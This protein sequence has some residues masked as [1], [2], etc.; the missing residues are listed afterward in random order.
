[1]I[2]IIDYNGG[3]IGSL[4]N[5]IAQLGFAYEIIEHGRQISSDSHII[6]AGVGSAKSTLEALAKQ[7]FIEPLCSIDN[8]ILGICIG[9]HLFFNQLE[10]DQCN[11][12]GI[13]DASILQF[14]K[15]MQV[16]H[17]GWNRVFH[18]EH[19]LFADIASGSY[20]YFAHSYYASNN[21]QYSIANCHYHLNYCTA[22]AKSNIYGVQF[23][24]EKSGE[25]GLEVLQNFI[26]LC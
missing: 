25:A 15:G 18:S 21:N 16:P 5:T 12:L 9:M 2:Q 24:I 22:F 23:H 3:N 4:S 6:I 8:P 26:T 17:I 14:P 20:F 13:I 7:H 10:E 11:G 19:P 1:M